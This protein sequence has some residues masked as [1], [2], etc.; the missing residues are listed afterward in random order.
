[1]EQKDKQFKHDRKKLEK[2]IEKLK[3]RVQ[4]LSTGKP[5]ELP[6]KIINLEETNLQILFEKYII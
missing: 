6:R 3:E 4:T 2:E 1:M 5:K